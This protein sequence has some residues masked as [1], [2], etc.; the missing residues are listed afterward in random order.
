MVIIESSSS[1]CFEKWSSFWWTLWIIQKGG[2]MSTMRTKVKII[3]LYLGPWISLFRSHS[4]LEL[5][6]Y[7]SPLIKNKYWTIYIEGAFFGSFYTR[8]QSQGC[9]QMKHSYWCNQWNQPKGF[10]HYESRLKKKTIFLIYHFMTLIWPQGK[11]G[12]I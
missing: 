10:L 11:K 5:N 3:L 7:L 2:W 8:N 6:V 12:Y 1:I 9:I 4:N